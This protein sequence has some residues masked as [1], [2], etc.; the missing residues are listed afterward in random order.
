MA[1]ASA[2]DFVTIPEEEQEEPGEDVPPEALSKPAPA[3]PAA[4]EPQG[5]IADP[6]RGPAARYLSTCR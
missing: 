4:T 6:C 1:P 5:F 3:T 2:P